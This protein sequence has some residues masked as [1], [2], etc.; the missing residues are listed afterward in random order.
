VRPRPPS[1]GRPTPVKVRPR[2]PAPGRIAAHRRVE[3]TRGLAL[4]FRLLFA[5]AVIALCAGVLFAATGGIGKVAASVGS[6]FSG[7][8]ADLTATPA[9]SSTASLLSDAP[10]LEEP[11]EPYT[12]QAAVDLVGS[13]PANL[14]GNDDLRIRIFV[15]LGD[16][17]P[18]AVTE[19]PVGRTQRF[20]VPG[21]TLIE[22]SNAFTAKIVGPAGLS[23]ASPVVTYIL[24]SAKPKVKLSSPKNGAVINAKTVKLA[25]QTQPRS[26]LRAVNTSTNAAVTGA[27]DANGNFSLILSIGTGKNDITVTATD[28]AGNEN[29]FAISVRKGAG[30]LVATLSASDYRIS[31]KSL[32]ERVTMSVVVAD[33]DGRPLQGAKVT[34]LI[35]APSVSAVSSKTL[36]TNSNGIATWATTISN[37]ATTGEVS[38]TVIIKTTKYGETTDLT[39]ITIAK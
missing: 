8:F 36:T 5:V 39:V 2:T 23:E 12:N 30:V 10:V 31:L 15:A 38:A 18:G 20:I 6:T 19:I 24:D 27:A 29:Q 25:G 7:F 35:A 4:P 3:R 34:F 9:P 28:P 14:V 16:Q 11:T 22:G 32:P 37:R 26:E 13:V 17:A 21:I 33:P 1:S